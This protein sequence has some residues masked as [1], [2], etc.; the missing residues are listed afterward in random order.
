MSFQVALQGNYQ[1]CTAL[2]LVYYCKGNPLA[3]S[4]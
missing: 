4:G 3:Y 2:L 1:A